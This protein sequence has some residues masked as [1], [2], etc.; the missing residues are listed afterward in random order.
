MTSIKLQIN[1][2]H[3]EANHKRFEHCAFKFGSYLGSV[4]W[5]LNFSDSLGGRDAKGYPG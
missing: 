5:G 4:I 2:K 1:F 3:Q